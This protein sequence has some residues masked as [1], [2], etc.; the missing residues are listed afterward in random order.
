MSPPTFDYVEAQ[1]RKKTFGI[2]T[3]IDPRGRPHST[4]VLYGVGPV[5]A[6]LAL[7]IVTF[8]HYAKV[9]Y[10]RA[11]PIVTLAV[12]FPHRILSFAPAS[13]VSFRGRATTVAFSDP[14][15][16]WAFRQHRILRDNLVMGSKGDRPLFIRID[17]EPNVLCYGL[18]ISLNA[19]RKDPTIG[20]YNVQIPVRGSQ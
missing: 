9:R 17:P 14:R 13:C 16:G 20:G 5:T 12:T 3:A 4:G 6:P 15:A 18:G 19:I 8:E 1:V 2:F 10:V 7:Y 11:N